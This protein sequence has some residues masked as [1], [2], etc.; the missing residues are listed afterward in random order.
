MPRFKNT[1]LLLFCIGSSSSST[2]LS[3]E[4]FAFLARLFINLLLRLF[5]KFWSSLDSSVSLSAPD[6]ASLHEL[7]VSS[8]SLG[9]G[10]S[11]RECGGISGEGGI[12]VITSGWNVGEGG[13]SEKK[14][15]A[16]QGGTRME[17]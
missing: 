17:F 13:R 12:D 8:T 16:W 9:I 14:L 11:E 5:D 1:F 3:A 15:A 6:S 7:S 4:E 2:L 10:S